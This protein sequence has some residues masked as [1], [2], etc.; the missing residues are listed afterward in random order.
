MVIP[1]SMF[2]KRFQQIK[3]YLAEH[4]DA[5]PEL[6]EAFRKVASDFKATYTP[7]AFKRLLSENAPVEGGLEDDITSALVLCNRDRARRGSVRDEG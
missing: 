5:P 4:G 3:A 6:V 1:A 7:D 2:L